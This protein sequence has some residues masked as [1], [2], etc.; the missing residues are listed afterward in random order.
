VEQLEGQNTRWWVEI[1]DSYRLGTGRGKL[2]RGPEGRPP[3][4]PEKLRSFVFIDI[5]ALFPRFSY[6]G[7]PNFCIYGG[8]FAR[9]AASHDFVTASESLRPTPRRDSSLSKLVCQETE[10][11][12]NPPIGEVDG[13]RT[14]AL[15]LY[16]ARGWT[17]PV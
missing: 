17:R 2:C 7:R 10:S 11:H 8:K 6:C 16:A 9:A 14:M 13:G 4:L 3:S 15:R 12:P 5:L 1:H